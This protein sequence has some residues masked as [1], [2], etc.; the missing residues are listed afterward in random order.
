MHLTINSKKPNVLLDRTEVQGKIQFEGATPSN[1][2]L[3]E[4]LSKECKSNAQLVI[5][6]HIYTQFG[7]QEATFEAIVY[8]NLESK[9]KTELMTKHLKKKIDEQK[10]AQ[11]ATKAA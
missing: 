4:A 9:H 5:V 6:K 7:T 3:S 10:K 1:I 8:H 11:E 2:I